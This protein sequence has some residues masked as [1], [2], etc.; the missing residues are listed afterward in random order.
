NGISAAF[1]FGDRLSPIHVLNNTN[2]LYVMAIDCS[3]TR[4]VCASL[5]IR[6][7]LILARLERYENRAQSRRR[8]AFHISTTK[9]VRHDGSLLPFA[10][11]AEHLCA[12]RIGSPV[13]RV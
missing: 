10:R 12:W 1:E 6:A 7:L 5:Y 2:N 9:G 11:R 4:I 8:R 13:R 3:L